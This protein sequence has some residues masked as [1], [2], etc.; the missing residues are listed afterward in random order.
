[1]SK[2][3]KQASLYVKT[4]VLLSEIIED[5]KAKGNDL[6]GHTSKASI[7]HELVNKEHAKRGLK[8]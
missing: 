1:M 2:N 3:H 5:L 6:P 4:H 8:K 7:I